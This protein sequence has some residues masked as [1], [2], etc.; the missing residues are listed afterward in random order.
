MSEILRRSIMPFSSIPEVLEDLRH[1]VT[2]PALHSDLVASGGHLAR[3]G[4]YRVMRRH[5]RRVM[6]P[7]PGPPY[8]QTVK[9]L[10]FFA[11]HAKLA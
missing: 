4:R 3:I 9:A 7:H 2:E 11:A 10:E 1:G 5:P 6:L 8:V